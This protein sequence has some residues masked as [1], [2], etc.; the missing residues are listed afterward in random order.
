M[1]FAFLDSAWLPKI[2]M[3]ATKSKL[4]FTRLKVFFIT[5]VQLRHTLFIVLVGGGEG[6]TWIKPLFE[7]N[8]KHLLAVTEGKSKIM[9]R[10]VLTV[11]NY[12]LFYIWTNRESPWGFN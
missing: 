7:L 1:L 11:Q 10:V 8:F 6:L 9:I 4:A 5:F 2:S 3:R 12:T